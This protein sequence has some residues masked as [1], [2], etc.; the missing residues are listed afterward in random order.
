MHQAPL[1]PFVEG[2]MT[3]AELRAAL[4]NT[5]QLMMAQAQVVTN[6]FLSQGN[7]RGRPQ[8]NVSTPTSRIRDFMKMNPPTFHGTKVE[9]DPQSFIYEI[10]KVVDTMGVNPRERADLAAYHIKDV[11]Q[12][13]FQ[14]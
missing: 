3:N 13:W 8:P 6:H 7:Q 5:T 12:V 14:Q 4:M 10:F 2:D 11:A 9:E 1:D